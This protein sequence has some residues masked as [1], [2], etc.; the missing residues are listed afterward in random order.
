[1]PYPS[2]SNLVDFILFDY[3]FQMPSYMPYPPPCNPEDRHQLCQLL[4]NFY[5]ILEVHQG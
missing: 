1:M 4:Q 3:S 2:P 5:K